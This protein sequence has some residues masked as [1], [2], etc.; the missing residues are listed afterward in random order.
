MP[1]RAQYNWA[2]T[3]EIYKD[4]GMWSLEGYKSVGRR[5]N[6]MIFNISPNGDRNA[7]FNWNTQGMV[8]AAASGLHP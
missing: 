3:G 1:Q 8:D 7:D 6:E 2:G 5:L 4:L